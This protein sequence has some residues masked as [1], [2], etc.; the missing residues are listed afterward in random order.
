VGKFF[1]SGN[2]VGSFAIAGFEQKEFSDFMVN[3]EPAQFFWHVC[4]YQYEVVEKVS[5]AFG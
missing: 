5:G 3:H 4:V 2:R 1:A